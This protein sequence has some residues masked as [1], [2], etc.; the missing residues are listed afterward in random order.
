MQITSFSSQD[1]FL[2]ASLDVVRLLLQN[3]PFAIIGLSGGSTPLPLYEAMSQDV[4]LDYSHATFFLL[5]ER[6]VSSEHADS[7]QRMVRA[8]LFSGTIDDTRFL[9]PRTDLPLDRCIKDYQQRLFQELPKTDEGVIT[10]DLVILGMGPDGHIA[11]L[12][13]PLSSDAFGPSCVMHT[14][15]DQFAVFDRITVTMPVLVSAQKRL[16]LIAG[17]EKIDLLTTMQSSSMDVSRYPAHALFDERTQWMV[18]NL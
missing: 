10:S 3:N 4:S 7:N 1:H 5:D 16:F 6:F 2:C 11:S 15:T 17:R 12:F 18:I 9:A 13:P 8:S 14:T